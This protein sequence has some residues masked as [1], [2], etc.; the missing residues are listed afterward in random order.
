VGAIFLDLSG[1]ALAGRLTLHFFGFWLCCLS[2]KLLLKPLTEKLRYP[3]E[4][5]SVIKKMVAVNHMLFIPLVQGSREV[6]GKD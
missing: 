1:Y 4:R 5:W 6:A 2:Q 3:E